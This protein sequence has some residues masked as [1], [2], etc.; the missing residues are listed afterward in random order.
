MADVRFGILRKCQDCRLLTVAPL[1]YWVWWM[2]TYS[3]THVNS[4]LHVCTAPQLVTH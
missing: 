4:T 1:P 2:G 3:Y